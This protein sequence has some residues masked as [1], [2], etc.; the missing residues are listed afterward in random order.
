MSQKKGKNI[1]DEVW[2]TI[3]E[4]HNSVN[5]KIIP[6]SYLKSL[7]PTKDITLY[8]QLHLII[9]LREILL[10]KTNDLTKHIEDSYKE[11]FNNK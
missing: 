6:N 4:L 5:E 9:Y 8:S 1:I 2:N 3:S 7:D 11:L 10:E